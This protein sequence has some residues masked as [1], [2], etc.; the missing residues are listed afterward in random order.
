MI[1]GESRYCGH[2]TLS[3][4]PER[5]KH[6]QN[7]SDLHRIH[8][9]GGIYQTNKTFVRLYEE[10]AKIVTFPSRDG[11]EREYEPQEIDTS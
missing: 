5:K 11:T 10:I 1:R 4:R 3:E 2:H 6:A 8:T 9:Q 7:P